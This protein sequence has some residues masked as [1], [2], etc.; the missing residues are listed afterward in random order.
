[1]FMRALDSFG[2]AHDLRHIF[3][4][5]K[6]QDEAY[7]LSA[8]IH[9]QL[10]NAHISILDHDTKGAVESC[11]IARE[12]IDDTMP[13]VVADCDVY[14][15]SDEYFQRVF[16]SKKPDGMLLTFNSND[17]R[18]SY[19]EVGPDGAVLR[20]AEK[21]VISNHAILGGYFFNNGKLFKEL[22]MEFTSRPLPDQLNEYFMSHLFNMLVEHHGRVEISHV[23]KKYIFGTP[24]ELHAYLEGKQ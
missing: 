19:V 18:Y 13:I 6:D 24:D 7:N 14:F 3:V 2:M 1:M 5:R 23:N 12:Y 17:P 21:V 4:V 8:Q 16:A 11:L 9:A 20:T 15:E 22:A 10:P